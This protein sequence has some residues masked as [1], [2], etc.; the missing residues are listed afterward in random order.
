MF[1]PRCLHITFVKL[2]MMLVGKS[3]AQ[4]FLSG[5]FIASLATSFTSA[6]LRQNFRG[7]QDKGWGT[8]LSLFQFCLASSAHRLKNY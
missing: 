1:A 7:L 8:S 3:I 2:E 6:H 4:Y 5:F